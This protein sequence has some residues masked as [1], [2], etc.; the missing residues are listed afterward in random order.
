MLKQILIFLAAIGLAVGVTG[1]KLIRMA[2]I[3][4]WLPGATTETRTITQTWHQTPDQH[5]NGRDT[6]WI[7]WTQEDIHI[8][9]PHRLNVSPEKWSS[10]QVGQTLEV[11]SLPNDR[12]IYLEEGIYASTGNFV[13][14]LLLL[15]AELGTAA[16]V[17]IGFLREIRE[18]RSNRP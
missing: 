8:V 11:R 18:E 4:G 10:L 15:A 1:P 5:P 9:G 7:S 12:E 17:A 3:R 14:D 16:G 2:K 6:Y 13:F